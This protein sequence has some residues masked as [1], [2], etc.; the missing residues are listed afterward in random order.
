M[1]TTTIADGGLSFRNRSRGV[2]LGLVTIAMLGTGVVV[3]RATVDEPERL[4]P[5]EQQVAPGTSSGSVA[6]HIGRDRLES[7]CFVKSGCRRL[8]ID[9]P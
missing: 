5:R 8:V 2:L 1:D 7:G 3:G 4:A 6:G 9:T